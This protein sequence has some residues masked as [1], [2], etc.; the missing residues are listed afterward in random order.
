MV[1]LQELSEKNSEYTITLL[2]IHLLSSMVDAVH[3][4]VAIGL[5][6]ITVKACNENEYK[7]AL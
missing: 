5:P 2:L 4:S 7:E 6:P 1:P 3:I